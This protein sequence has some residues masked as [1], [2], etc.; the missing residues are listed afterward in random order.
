MSAHVSEHLE[1]HYFN[2]VIILRRNKV[3]TNKELT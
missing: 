2:D 3:G 1:L